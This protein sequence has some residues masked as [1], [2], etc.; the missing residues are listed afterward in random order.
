MVLLGGVALAGG[1]FDLFGRHLAAIVS[2]VLVIILLWTRPG[3]RIGFGG[4]FRLI[5]GLLGT[6]TLLTA[7]SLLWSN[8][9]YSTIVELDRLIAYIG[10][11]TATFLVCRDE[12]SRWLFVEGLL[13]AFAIVLIA[14]LGDRL[15][16]GID[17]PAG[18]SPSRLSFPLGYWNANGLVF[19]ISIGAFAWASRE[20]R[21]AV[22]RWT[23]A[24]LIPA[25][26]VGLY[27]TYS[28]GGLWREPSC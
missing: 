14:A 11:L 12:R 21:F 25:A 13:L 27:F 26:I 5:L 3:A 17:V 19:G 8:S 15:F 18:I 16:P 6:L 2:W 7:L 24:A 28:R 20:S 23:A 1:G 10:F 4:P 9:D 22:S